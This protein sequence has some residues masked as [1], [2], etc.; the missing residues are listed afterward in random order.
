MIDNINDPS[1]IT[2]WIIIHYIAGLFLFFIFDLFIKEELLNF[3]IINIIHLNYELKDYYYTYFKLYDSS[4]M[5]Y[6]SSQNTL[7]NSI[8]D[9]ILFLMGIYTAFYLK[10]NKNINK[11]LDICKKKY[12]L[13][14]DNKY[15]FIIVFGIIYFIISYL[16]IYYDID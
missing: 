1:L 10:Y 9:T 15:I 12:K 4:F 3:I 6:F 14:L 5:Y 2:P 13:K 16:F 8:G 11:N 7:I